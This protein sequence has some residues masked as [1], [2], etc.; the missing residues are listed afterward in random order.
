MSLLI[1]RSAGNACRSTT[2]ITKLATVTCSKD[3]KAN[4]G[5]ETVHRLQLG[6]LKRARGRLA[7]AGGRD[8]WYNWELFRTHAQAL[9]Y[10]ATKMPA[11]QVKRVASLTRGDSGYQDGFRWAVQTETQRRYHSFS[12]SA[13]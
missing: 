2:Q 6:C 4:T 8:V 3:T 1:L 12:G 10:A 7:L 9:T 11:S 5:V 13:V